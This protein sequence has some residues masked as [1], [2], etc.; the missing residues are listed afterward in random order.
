MPVKNLS[1]RMQI[2]GRG[3]SCHGGHSAIEQ[4]SYIGRTTLYSEYDGRTYYP[5][6]AEDLVH[7]EVMLPKNAPLKYK[8]PCVL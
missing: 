7:S 2:C 1:T 4:S 6:Y 8:E 5:K 3:A